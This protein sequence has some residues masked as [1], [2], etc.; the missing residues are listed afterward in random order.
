MRKKRL[1]LH[2]VTGCYIKLADMLAG[3]FYQPRYTWFRILE[4]VAV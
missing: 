3:T 4:L 2:N 1:K